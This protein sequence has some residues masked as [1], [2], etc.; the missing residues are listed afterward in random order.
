MKNYHYQ[1]GGSLAADDPT[2]V[3]RQ[4]DQDLYEGLK[5]GKFCYVLNSR[6]MGKSSLRVRTM[7]RLEAEGVNCGAIDLSIIGSDNVTPEGWYKGVF[8]ELV[9]K[10]ELSA[11]IN[12]RA[13][14]KERE[15]L[16][17]V[18]RLSEFIE[19]VLLVEIRQ[20][21]VIFIDEVDS[22]LS[23]DSSTDDFFALIRAC[24]N[25]R[26]DNLAYK[27]LSF[28]LLGVA[29]PSYF[30]Q[31]K[32]RTSFN[33]GQAVEVCGF[34]LEEAQPLAVGLVGRVSNPQAVLREIL[35]WTGGQPFL[36]QKLCQIVQDA[37]GDFP[38]F[39]LERGE[40]EWVEQL[41]RS[42]IIEN[43]ES[44]DDP[45]HLRTIRDRILGKGQRSVDLLTLYLQILQEK[46]VEADGS[47]EQ[48]ELRLSGLVVKRNDSLRVY[49]RIYE[50]V[51]AK[52][53][54]NKTLV[55]L[56]PYGE[57]L[58][59]WIASDE[60]DKT[61]LLRGREL[62]QA[63][64]WV[65]NRKNLKLSV[66]DYQ[67]LNASQA[68]QRRRVQKRLASG[69]LGSVMFTI[70]ILVGFRENIIYLINESS[71][72][73]AA[74][75]AGEEQFSE[76]E[77]T[78]F[79][80]N[81]NFNRQ[82]GIEEFR[83][84]NYSTATE[85]FK[86]AKETNRN[87]PEMWIYYNNARA[88]K[89]GNPLTLA[90]V[91]P[92]TARRDIALEVLRGV[93]QAQDSF[94]ERREKF[95][96]PL[97][98]IIIANDDS[99]PTQARRVARTLITNQKVMG[100]IG[101]YTS[102]ASEAA[103]KEYEKAGLAM[104]SPSSTSNTLKGDVFFRTVSS[105]LETAKKLLNYVLANKIKKVVIFYS[106][107]DLY[108]RDLMESVESLLNQ[109]D[110]E[111]IQKVDLRDSELSADAEAFL[112]S[113]IQDKPDALFLFPNTELVSVAIEIARAR[114]N[115]KSLQNKPLLGASSLYSADT[116]KAGRAALENLIL[117]VHWFADAPDSKEFADK[118]R[119][120]WKGQVSWRT[121]TSYEATQA[122]IEA[123]SVSD[124]P[125][126][127]TVLEKLKSMNLSS[128]EPVLVKVSRGKGGPEG[129]EFRF[130][131]AE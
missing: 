69:L 115:V 96:A 42:R 21:I 75:V 28:A 101:H 111:V 78:F 89:K 77:N 24:C 29:K 8:Y 18:Q 84:E 6:Q 12:R 66:Q 113:K 94:N 5:G 34:K 48:T 86:R 17:P 110:V 83:K 39:S 22:V 3:V 109:K 32:N 81:D 60:Q 50:A 47:L 88:I 4:A 31:D 36:T 23:L 80:S 121:A 104:I 40:Q 15:S 54:V 102:S 27:R 100:V 57:A 76:G 125:S 1:V 61:W 10:F 116:L 43:W 73:L 59:K 20:N 14:W 45:E 108:S 107:E 131:L 93:A 2:Y 128:Q 71:A 91:T 64:A 79:P 7:K 25:Q 90:V 53:W 33:I 130:E 92:A 87:D 70:G 123:L 11:K 63:Q 9:R 122:F 120:M 106:P 51:F 55:E 98:K 103:L 72:Y 82:I 62:R 68:L 19:D 119:D 126:R 74:Q 13:W 112:L 56:R 35:A 99:E 97:L 26:V 49:N 37:C 52:N 46:E 118:A 65:A 85:F 105:N 129:S 30:I 95:K 127:S 117:D 41:V 58:A 38:K 114:N 44:Q 124:K 67:F 16:S